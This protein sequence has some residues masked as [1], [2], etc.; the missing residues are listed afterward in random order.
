MLDAGKLA[1]LRAVVERGSFSAAGAA[2]GLT[3]PAVSRQVSLLERRLGT[4]LVRRTQHG[5]YATEAGRVL[6]EHG[7]AIL[8]RMEL[9][10]AEV[11]E[12]A[13]LRAGHV[14]LGSFFTALVFL[15]AELGVGLGDRHHPLFAGGGALI[16]DV[17]VDRGSAF[18]GLARGEIDVAIVFEHAFEPA[19]APPDVEV[20]ALFDDPP[21]VLLP[22]AH[23]RSGATEVAAA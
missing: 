22:R 10:E 19:P 1:T 13:G 21:C 18:R 16:D 14:R 12:I 5:V 20:V 23:P 2:I 11:A 15:S 7:A 3:Q 9:A 17:L 4:Q 6:L 8:D